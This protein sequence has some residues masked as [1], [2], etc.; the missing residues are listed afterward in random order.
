MS[1][2]FIHIGQCGNQLGQAFWEEMKNMSAQAPP[3]PIKKMSN[4][5][6]TQKPSDKVTV[7]GQFTKP[8]IP[9]SLPDGSLPCVLVDSEPKVVQRARGSQMLRNKVS[10]D[11]VFTDKTGR[12]N[13]WAFGYNGRNLRKPGGLYGPSNLTEFVLE[14]VRRTAE[15]CDR[16]TGTVLFHSLAGGTGS[17]LYS[18]FNNNIISYP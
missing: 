16:Y 9:Y 14:G 3:V 7:T 6:R 5:T 2:A 13:N 8:H 10:S 17:G 11:V 15:R 4:S 1:L 18:V 12:G